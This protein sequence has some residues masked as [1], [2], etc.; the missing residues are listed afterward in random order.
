MP[1]PLKLVPSPSPSPEA[2]HD[3]ARA[4]AAF[5]RC[6]PA[7]Q[8]LPADAVLRLNLD[9]GAAIVRVLG[10]LP[11]LRALAGAD[12]GAFRVLTAELLDGVEERALALLQEIG[13]A[14]V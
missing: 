4:P 5:A 11:A 7:M 8:A 3:E 6:L 10:S 9:V 12:Q 14:H 2:P 13:R 1:P